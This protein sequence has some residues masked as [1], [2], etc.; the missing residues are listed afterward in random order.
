V[1]EV[2]EY[3][4]FTVPR[5]GGRLAARPGVPDSRCHDET[6]PE[7]DYEFRDFTRLED[8]LVVAWFDVDHEVVRRPDRQR[9]CAE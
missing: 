3:L 5:S 8:D 7:F 4:A 9:E 1:A 2:I 6:D